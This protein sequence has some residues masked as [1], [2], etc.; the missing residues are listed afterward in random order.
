MSVSVPITLV[1]E[2][3][4]SEGRTL[5]EVKDG[6]N[7]IAVNDDTDMSVDTAIQNLADVI[8][9]LEGTYVNIELGHPS[10]RGSN[11]GTKK[12]LLRFRVKIGASSTAA[13]GRGGGDINTM[14][15]N[16][17]L[18][19]NQSNAQLM[20]SLVEAKNETKLQ[21]LMY[22][23]EELKK[24][25][26]A[27]GDMTHVDYFASKVLTGL[28]EADKVK[29]TIAGAKAAAPIA[30]A[31]EAPEVAKKQP[32]TEP[33]K[34]LQKSLAKLQ[35]LDPSGFSDNM[36]LLGNYAEQHPEMIQALLKQMKGE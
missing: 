33:A 32:K 31:A 1:Y 3:M 4:K 10:N 26:K 16:L 5:F 36:E 19:Q 2:K 7:T 24:E 27:K 35:K 20:Q 13:A 8:D 11:G 12:P 15:L 25:S 21:Q 14:L 28:I 6:A 17:M 18:Q 9:N 30:G 22:Q 29:T 34:K 23:M